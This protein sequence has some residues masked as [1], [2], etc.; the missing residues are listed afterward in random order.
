[1]CLDVL[2]LPVLSMQGTSNPEVFD[3][4]FLQTYVIDKKPLPYKLTQSCLNII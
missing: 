4:N 1:M 3:T 2:G